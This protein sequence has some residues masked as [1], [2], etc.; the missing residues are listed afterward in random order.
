[1]SVIKIS[2]LDSYL[3]QAIVS[4]KWNRNRKLSGNIPYVYYIHDYVYV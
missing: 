4:Y 2:S 3:S 1:M